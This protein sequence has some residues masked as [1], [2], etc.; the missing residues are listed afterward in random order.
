[1]VYAAIPSPSQGVVHLGPVPLR[2]YA[3][4]IIIGIVVAVVVTGRRLRARGIDP[5]IASE[6]AFWAVPFGIVGARIYHVISTPDAYFGA[7]GHVADVLKIW[8]GGLGIWGAIAGGAIGALIAARRV[9]VSL[10]LF[11]DAAA[12]GI[13]LAQAVGRW[14][15][16]FNQEL[17]GRPTTLPWALKIDVEHR[18][19]PAVGLYHPT[20]LYEFLWNL[21]V[22]GILFYVDRR[23]RLGRGR[24]FALYVAL[25][26]FGR[27]WIEMLRVDTAD[28]IL[29]LRVNIWVSAVVCLGA[30]VALLLIRRPVDLDVSPAEQRELGLHRD[31]RD[32]RGAAGGDQ[33]DAGHAAPETDADD[34]TGP[35]PGATTG[36]HANPGD[37]V[38]PGD[39]ADT[40]DHAGAGGDATT[41]GHLIRAEASGAAAA[42]RSEAPPER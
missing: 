36:D 30:V 9:G 11:A 31:R 25:Y 10:A 35:G 42:A 22:A 6:V 13:V 18:T 23:H 32:R 15:N 1:M 5:E 20:F 7:H 41:G 17:Y 8:N 2:A 38:N 27:L 3:L 26:T 14:G 34:D 33:L 24:L 28:H 21:L 4:M 19:D 16:W 12:P 29:G 39:H 40:G 37:H